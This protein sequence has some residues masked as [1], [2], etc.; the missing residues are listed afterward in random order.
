[1]INSYIFRQD[2][3]KRCFEAFNKYAMNILYG[4]ILIG[5]DIQ[6]DYKDE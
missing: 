1:M 5:S 3:Y 2:F 6:N 4:N